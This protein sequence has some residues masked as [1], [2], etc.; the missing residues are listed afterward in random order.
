MGRGGGYKIKSRRSKTNKRRRRDR[1][2]AGR[3]KRKKH[4]KNR[5]TE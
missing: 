2:N 5:L 4:W 1:L 3:R